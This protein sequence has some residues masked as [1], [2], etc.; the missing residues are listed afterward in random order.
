MLQEKIPHCNAYVHQVLFRNPQM[1]SLKILLQLL[2][3]FTHCISQSNMH[4]KDSHTVGVNKLFHT[5]NPWG[6][7]SVHHVS[8]T[9]LGQRH[10]QQWALP[11]VNTWNT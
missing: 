6:S 9:R 11:E 7:E 1:R 3:F 8:D 4:E 10:S 5:C 2:W